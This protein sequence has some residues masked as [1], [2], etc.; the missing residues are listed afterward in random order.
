MK[1]VL[2]AIKDNAIEAFQPINSV[3]ARGEAMRAFQDAIND[4]NNKQLN[5]HP[6]DF[7]LYH[8][9]DFDDQTGT[10]LAITPER[11][12]RGTDAKKT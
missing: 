3:R 1:Y 12:M 7:D 6:E 5:A 2:V 9:G 11:I 8:V 10:L 4:P